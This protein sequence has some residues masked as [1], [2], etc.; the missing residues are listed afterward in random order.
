MPYQSTTRV[1]DTSTLRGE[2]LDE[3]ELDRRESNRRY[4]RAFQV[5]LSHTSA[6]IGNVAEDGNKY[7]IEPDI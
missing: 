4:D 6:A 1:V 7:Q 2:R 5:V 3:F